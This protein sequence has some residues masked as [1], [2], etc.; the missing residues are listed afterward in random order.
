MIC[1][2]HHHPAFKSR[3]TGDGAGERLG[4]RIGAYGILV[5]E[6]EVKKDT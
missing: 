6:P 2:L 4:K 3:I 1:S 5:G